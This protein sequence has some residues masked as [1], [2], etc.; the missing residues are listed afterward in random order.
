METLLS[1]ENNPLQAKVSTTSP[2]TQ[3]TQQFGN[4][5]ASRQSIKDPGESTG[6]QSISDK[7]TTEGI[8]D[9]KG[10]SSGMDDM[11]DAD[12]EALHT[13]SETDME[14]SST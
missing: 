9:G 4:H 6:A 14:T 1:G 11:A 3:D 10:E 2:S 7:T 13:G 8:Q 12:T 5:M